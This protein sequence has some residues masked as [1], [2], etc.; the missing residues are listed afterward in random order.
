MSHPKL[1]DLP[2]LPLR[3]A[4]ISPEY[5]ELGGNG[6]DE[7]TRMNPNLNRVRTPHKLSGE[8]V[9]KYRRSS[10]MITED[11]GTSYTYVP[12]EDNCERYRNDLILKER[13]PYWNI[14]LLPYMRM[15]GATQT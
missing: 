1:E 13:V 11:R 5:E 2:K 15:S 14:D 6:F 7:T 10:A 8:E 9:E 4:K 12:A 3:L